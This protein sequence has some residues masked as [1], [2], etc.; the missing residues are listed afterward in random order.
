MSKL[1]FS[2]NSGKTITGEFELSSKQIE[3]LNGIGGTHSSNEFN[4]EILRSND[5]VFFFAMWKAKN[6]NSASLITALHYGDKTQKLRPD[7]AREHGMISYYVMWPK[8]LISFN[9][10]HSRTEPGPIDRQK[11]ILDLSKLDFTVSD[12]EYVVK[13]LFGHEL[14]NKIKNMPLREQNQ[15]L[16][17]AKEDPTVLLQKLVLDPQGFK[18]NYS[19][20]DRSQ[21]DEY[22]MELKIPVAVHKRA[23]IEEN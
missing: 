8:D 11:T 3:K 7:Y 17:Q 1:V 23:L 5:N 9:R 19:T 20:K 13:S 6:S 21:K 4:T 2:R 10:L 14:L 22:Y 15:Y 16:K 18:I 12:F